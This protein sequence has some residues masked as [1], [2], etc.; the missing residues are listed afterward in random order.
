MALERSERLILGEDRMIHESTTW[1]EAFA[2][3]VR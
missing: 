3:A 1:Q 2:A